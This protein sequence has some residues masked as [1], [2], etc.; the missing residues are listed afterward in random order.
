IGGQVFD[1]NMPGWGCDADLAWRACLFGWTSLYEPTAV[2]HHIRTYSPTTRAT[3]TP[4]DRRTQFRNRLLMIAKNDSV[5]DLAR[6]AVPLLVYEALALGYAVLRERELLGGY[7]E[8][9]RRLPQARRDRHEIQRRRRVPRVPFG[10]QPH[11]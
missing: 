8:A 1:E 3:A 4:A 5:R 6:D 2:V 11:P 10:L 9:W 7:V